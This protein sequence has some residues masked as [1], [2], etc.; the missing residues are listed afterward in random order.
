MKDQF[1]WIYQGKLPRG[2][3]W[4]FF[5]KG[6]R[7]WGIEGQLRDRVRGCSLSGSWEIRTW[8]LWSQEILGRPL[9]GG[10]DRREGGTA[11]HSALGAY[12]AA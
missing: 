4:I 12:R 9:E 2:G 3:D 7:Y 1:R 10:G 5:Y 6:E 11:D 8:V